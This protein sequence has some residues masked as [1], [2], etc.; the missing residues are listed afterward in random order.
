MVKRSRARVR[1]FVRLRRRAAV[2]SGRFADA[3][4]AHDLRQADV[5]LVFGVTNATMSRWIGGLRI[6]ERESAIKIAKF[7]RTLET[8]RAG[9][10]A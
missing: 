4:K 6:P 1:R 8:N 2:K 10:P 9:V 3:L 5:A 7:L